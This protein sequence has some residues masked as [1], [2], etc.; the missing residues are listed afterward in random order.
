MF[1]K[2]SVHYHNLQESLRTIFIFVDLFIVFAF[3]RKRLKHA[4]H[5]WMVYKPV[6]SSE[7]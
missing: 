3:I 2:C 4:Q 7:E 1:C 5:A 6:L